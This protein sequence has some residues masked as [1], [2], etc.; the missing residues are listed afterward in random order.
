MLHHGLPTCVVA[1]V[2]VAVNANTFTCGGIR[3]RTSPSL[4]NSTLNVSPLK[5]IMKHAQSIDIDQV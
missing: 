3:L 4:T 1:L 5:V 2:A